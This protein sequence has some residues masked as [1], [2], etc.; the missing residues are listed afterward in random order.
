MKSHARMPDAWAFRNCRHAGDARRGAPV[1]PGQP[2]EPPVAQVV[3]EAGQPAGE[4]DE[5]EEHAERGR[6]ELPARWQ[7]DGAALDD[8]GAEDGAEGRPQPAHGGRGEHDEAHR[9]QER[10][11]LVGLVHHE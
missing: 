2:L 1:A 8:G 11:L 7:V 4:E 10:R 5:D 9:H 3:A 6:E